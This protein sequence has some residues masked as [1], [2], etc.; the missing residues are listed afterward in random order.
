[1]GSE[2]IV[3]NDFEGFFAGFYAP[4]FDGVVGGAGCEEFDV[5]G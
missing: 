4:D 3:V 1:M 2:F 5:W